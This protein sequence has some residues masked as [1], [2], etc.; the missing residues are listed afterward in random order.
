MFCELVLLCVSFDLI[1]GFMELG[2]FCQSLFVSVKFSTLVWTNLIRGHVKLGMFCELV[3]L[4]VSFVALVALE[5]LLL[6]VRPHVFLQVT[7]R[8]ASVVALVTLV[9]LFS[10]VLPHYVIFQFTSLNTR[11]LAHCASVLLFTRVGPFVLLQ[12][13]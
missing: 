8:G 9:W 3:L 10:C 2:M 7:R 11:K 5:R 1:Q 12:G 6:S 4:C 13:A